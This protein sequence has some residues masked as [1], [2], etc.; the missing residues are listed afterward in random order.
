MDKIKKCDGIHFHSK[1]FVISIFIITSEDIIKF[2][3]CNLTDMIIVTYMDDYKYI[4]RIQKVHIAKKIKS[5]TKI[6]TIYISF[7]SKL[8]LILF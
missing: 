2:Y 3:Q 6:K 4:Y 5:L 8:S 7:D 1:I